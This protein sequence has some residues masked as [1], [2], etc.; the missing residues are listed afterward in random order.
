MSGQ[1]P[2]V[3]EGIPVFTGDLALLDTKVTELAG[4]GAG[5][6]TATGDIHSS[7]GGLQAFYKAPEAD[8]LFATTK[9]VADRGAALKSDLATITAALRTYSDDAHPLVEK[10]RQLK[11]DAGAFL[12]KVNA[13]DKWRE[14]GDLVEE[15]NR[16]HAEIAETWAAFQAVELACYNK[17]ISLVP[18]GKPLTTDD[19]SGGEHTYGY[20]S[21]VLNQAKGLP[22]GD[23]VEESKP[24]YHLHEHGWDFVK[25]F[26]VD[27]VLG[28]VKG[29]GTLVGVD[30][31]EGMKQAW[32][33][34]AQLSVGAVI[35]TATSGAGGVYLLATPEEHLPSWL[36]GTSRAMKET[37]KALIAY[38]QWGENPARAGGAVTFNVLTTVFTGGTGAGV[39]GA[40]KAALA[41]K[42]ISFANKASRVVD[43]TTYLFK[44]AGAGL[45]KISN[46]M[47]GLKDTGR[48]EIPPLPPGVVT[49]P[50]GAYK[51]AD[52]TLHLPE[53]AAVPEGAFEIPEG[54]VK[55]PDGAELPSGA[56]DLGDGIVHL[57]EGTTPPAG[58]LPIQAGSLKLPEGTTALPEGT[59]RGFGEEGN[60]VLLDREGNILSG[61]GTL[62]QHHSN[63]KRENPPADNPAPAEADT[64]LPR[65]P[66][67]ESALV[68]TGARGGNDTVRLGSDLGGTG[69]VGDDLTHTGEGARNP[70][71]APG[72]TASNMP[73]NSADNG[74]PDGG[75]RGGRDE[76][77]PVN[78]MDGGNST[79]AGGRDGHSIDARD[80]SRHGDGHEPP[81]L[82]GGS[83]VRPDGARYVEEPTAEHT[84]AAD[85]YDRVRADPDSLDITRISENTG[86]SKDALDRVRT[87]FFLTEH[88]VAD[89][90]GSARKAYFTPRQDIA[91]ILET[92]SQRN[93]SPEE[94]VKFERFIAHE[95]IESHLM[96]AGI[97][98]LREHPDAWESFSNDGGKTIEYYHTWPR[99]AFH[100]GA[101]DLS[102]NEGTGGFGHWRSLGMD[103]S[104]VEVAPRLK[105]IDDVVAALKRELLSKGIE[106]K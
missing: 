27:G 43:P 89:A 33:G 53:G 74:T 10:L 81:P 84:A 98:Y 88:V 13:E 6:A 72:G 78:S 12:V 68:G 63:A 14:D 70:D 54:S 30:G 62:L 59:A 5:I 41:A 57:P 97:P 83:E 8:Q 90:P 26:A 87:H 94:V 64:P 95:Y 52:G 65:T 86:V 85:F 15:N 51:V 91:A 102:L 40:G 55:L 44:G 82:G 7:F 71:R 50:D 19:G 29:L 45:T 39:S 21:E 101:H 105:N 37:G 106:L 67:H 22:W 46:V 66:A 16:R 75:S 47:T 60:A 48:I 93:L 18:G 20:D 4:D 24:W 76:H 100:A 104:R 31:W 28:T 69:R 42:A 80:T 73:T 11:R 38:D 25:G 49:L 9:P 58:S 56:V 17:I 103:A 96:E 34:L 23:P 35:T 2:V 32:G 36:R 99:N 3:L 92:A 1:Q 61:D 79:G 77:A